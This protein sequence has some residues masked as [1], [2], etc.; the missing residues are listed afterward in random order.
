MAPGTYGEISDLALLPGG[1]QVAWKSDHS[2]VGLQDVATGAKVRTFRPNNGDSRPEEPLL[3]AP[4][5]TWLMDRDVAWD[6]ASGEIIAQGISI[7]DDTYAGEVMS[8]DSRLVYKAMDDGIHAWER[9]T[10]EDIHTFGSPR[11]KVKGVALSPDGQR[12]AAACND[13]TI[14]MLDVSDG[15]AH[16]LPAEPR[17]EEEFAG[18]WR[19]MGGTDHWAANVAIWSLAR[20]G[21]PAVD[22][23]ARKLTPAQPL[24]P[25][26]LAELRRQIAIV[27]TPPEPDRG[28][29]SGYSGISRPAPLSDAAIARQMAARTL[30]D[31]G[32]VLT[33]AE[34]DA[35]R[36]GMKDRYGSALKAG[37]PLPLPDRLRSSRAIGALE[38]ST[39]PAAAR[40]LLEAL[41]AGD[42]KDPQTIEASSAL[43]FLKKWP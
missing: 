8:P 22:F 7:V 41:A 25:A 39:T 29:M 30:H 23:L 32:V 24:A 17:S 14:L 28:A 9:L 40:P 38:H 34:A 13:G 10:A 37:E 3:V 33:P 12:L 43:Q 21:Q 2:G 5:G 16:G 31:H 20:A 1:R 19:I 35:A 27:D 4:D 18:L 36:S 6:M 42:A 11:M 26:Q 15:T